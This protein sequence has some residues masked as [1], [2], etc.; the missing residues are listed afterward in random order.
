[1]TERGKP[2]MQRRAQSRRWLLF[3]VLLAIVLVVNYPLITMFLNSL[4]STAEIMSS[5]S[6]FPQHVTFD[7]YA[8]LNSRTSFWTFFMNSIIVGGVGTLLSIICAALA[9]YALSR[10]RTLIVRSYSRF[11]LMVQMFPL[12]L[13]LIPLFILFR[14]LGLVNSYWSVILLYTV[15]NLPF[16]TWMFAGFFDAIPRE[17]EEAALTDGCT[18]LQAFVRIVLRLSGPGIGAVSIF[19]FLFSYNEYLIASVFLRDPSKM[20]IPVGIQ[21]FM[22][23]YSTDWGSLMASATLATLP[24]LVFFLF[25]QKYMVTGVVAGA[26]KG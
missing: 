15:V 3:C 10:Y 18:Q 8:Y 1:M 13:S 20:T 24:T 5:N 9:G 6:V 22:Q 7:N 14:N 12:I 26:V 2:A 19:S 23:Q 16:A 4:R 17:L 21:L 11:L 25:V